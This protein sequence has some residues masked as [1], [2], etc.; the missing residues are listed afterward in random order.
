MCT[1][2]TYHTKDFYF[3][4]NLDLEFSYNETVTVTPRN[5]PFRFRNGMDLNKHYA[6]IGMAT[7]S[8]GY[9]LYYEATNE[10]GL[11]IAGLNFP[12]H[13]VYYPWSPDE[14]NLSPFELIPWMLGQFKAV[15][16]VRE[17]LQTTNIW[18]EPFSDAFPLSPLH[19]IIS[20]VT[21]S[22]TLETTKDG[23]RVY[24]NPVGVLTNNPPFDYHMYNLANYMNITAAVPDNRFST[25]IDLKP[26]SLGMGA[27]GLPGDP[28]SASRF[29]KATFTK[30]NSL[31]DT[32]EAES[33]NQFFHILSSVAQQKGITQVRQQEYEFTLYSSCCNTSKGIYYYTT[34]G[35]RQISAVSMHHEDLSSNALI[36]YPLNKETAVYMHN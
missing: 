36:T 2:I 21:E 12:N 26:Y 22:I 27:I 23:M 33:V 16:Q 17:A 7:V 24:D 8:D 13:A 35:N 19:W 4:R 28:S 30:L 3:G 34:Y 29:I 9:P 31:S 6:L 14:V 20:D 1:A 18:N 32:S 25:K 15:K 10:H 5:Y 11:S